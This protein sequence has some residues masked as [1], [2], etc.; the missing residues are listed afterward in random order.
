VDTEL[1]HDLQASLGGAYTLERD[2][3]VKVLDPELARTACAERLT[4]EIRIAA[5]L[6]DAHIVPVLSAGVTRG[7]LPYYTMPLVHGESL[8]QRLQRSLVMGRPHRLAA[9]H[10]AW[11]FFEKWKSLRAA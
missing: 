11:Q 5:R 3:V 10:H 8:R 4:Q 7:G 6:Q 2:V 1:R 9:P